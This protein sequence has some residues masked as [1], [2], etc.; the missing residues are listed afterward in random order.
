MKRIVPQE[1]SEVTGFAETERFCLCQR[2]Q[3][4]CHIVSLLSPNLVAMLFIDNKTKS[5]DIQ[6]QL[7]D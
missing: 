4:F 7:N 1:S 2:K 6:E 3:L 5:F